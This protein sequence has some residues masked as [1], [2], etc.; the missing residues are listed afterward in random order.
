MLLV[1]TAEHKTFEWLRE[2][3]VHLVRG[4]PANT[5]RNKHTIITRKQRFEIIITCLLHFV[6]AAYAA[7]GF[8]CDIM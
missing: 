6:F 3:N 8:C 4:Y 2:I 1:P 5:K 7:D